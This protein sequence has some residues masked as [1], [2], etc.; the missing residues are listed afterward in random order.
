MIAFLHVDVLYSEAPESHAEALANLVELFTELRKPD[1]AGTC[2]QTLKT[3][4]PDSPWTARAIKVGTNSR[5]FRKGVGLCFSLN[6]AA[7]RCYAKA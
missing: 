1:H 2:L 7:R 4:Y 3:K 5:A 6:G